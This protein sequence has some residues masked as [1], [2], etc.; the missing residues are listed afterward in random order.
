MTQNFIRDFLLHEQWLLC[1]RILVRLLS[2]VSHWHVIAMKLSQITHSTH[3]VRYSLLSIMSFQILKQSKPSCFIEKKKGKMASALGLQIWLKANQLCHHR[4]KR[5][6]QTR[7]KE[8]LRKMQKQY[9]VVGTCLCLH[10]EYVLP[11]DAQV[12]TVMAS[13]HKALQN[14]G[15]RRSFLQ[16]FYRTLDDQLVFTYFVQMFIF[17]F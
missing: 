15:S 10:K 12:S 6:H 4:N 9:H 2:P 5:H 1:D 14:E 16:L 7:T 8:V 3:D 13:I 17:K 11:T